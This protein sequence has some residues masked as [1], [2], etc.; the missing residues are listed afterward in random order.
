MDQLRQ[1]LRDA[2]GKQKLGPTSEMVELQTVEPPK[3]EL[4]VMD[5]GKQIIIF[6]LESLQI[7]LATPDPRRAQ[8]FKTIS[9]TEIKQIFAELTQ[10]ASEMSLKFNLESL[11]IKDNNTLDY[12]REMNRDFSQKA[13]AVSPFI[14]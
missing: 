10:T 14:V 12:V 13:R 2:S 1:K 7:N 9:E 5:P 8:T 11:N 3:K 6:K 4:Q